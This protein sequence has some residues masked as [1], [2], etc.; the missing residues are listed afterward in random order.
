MAGGGGEELFIQFVNDVCYTDYKANG[1]LLANLTKH[2]EI[3]TKLEESYAAEL[4]DWYLSPDRKPGDVGMVKDDEGEV[5]GYQILYYCSN[6]PIWET[7]AKQKL[8][9]E[10]L[11]A[12]MKQ[13]ETSYPARIQYSKILLG[14]REEAEATKPSQ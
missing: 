13:V 10:R 4:K 8:R 14:E 9:D 6:K 1:G 12:A 5:Q 7:E 3:P 2:T 11:S